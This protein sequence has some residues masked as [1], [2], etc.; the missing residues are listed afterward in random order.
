[1]KLR[2]SLVALALSF[3]ASQHAEAAITF[4]IFSDLL[5]TQGGVAASQN[6]LVM[7]VADTSNDGFI[8]AIQ[9]GS[10][11]ALNGAI[12]GLSGDDFVLARWAIGGSSGTD[13]AFYDTTNELTFPGSVSGWSSG[14]PL[15]L[16]WFPTLTTASTLASTGDTYGLYSGPGSTGSAAWITP[17]DGAT[18]GLKFLMTDAAVDAGNLSPSLGDASLTVVAGVPEP[19]RSLLALLG[20]GVL[21]LRRRR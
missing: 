13:G 16:L 5:K 8:S 14:D 10:S 1:M 4:N 18:V 21:A 17:S 20:F 19:S 6:G 3:V 12:D 11:L 2:S 7:L 15:A 9:N